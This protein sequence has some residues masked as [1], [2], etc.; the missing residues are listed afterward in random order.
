MTWTSMVTL[1]SLL[2][3]MAS[4]GVLLARPC[5]ADTCYK[6]TI[7]GTGACPNQGRVNVSCEGISGCPATAQSAGCANTETG[8]LITC[9]FNDYDGPECRSQN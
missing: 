2:A 8:H 6:Q 4:S 7:A 9:C 3:T 1:G 5:R